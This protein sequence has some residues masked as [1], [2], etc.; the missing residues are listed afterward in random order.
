MSTILTMLGVKTILLTIFGLGVWT[1]MSVTRTR[2]AR[3]QQICWGFVLVVG[4]FGAAIP[5]GVTVPDFLVNNFNTSDTAPEFRQE[6]SS[7]MTPPRTAVRAVKTDIF[8]KASNT[9]PVTQQDVAYQNVEQPALLSHANSNEI[10]FST[11][12]KTEPETYIHGMVSVAVINILAAVWLGGITVLVVLTSVSYLRLRLELKSSV[13]PADEDLAEWKRICGAANVSSR[14]IGLLLTKQTGPALVWLSPLRATVVVP[15]EFWYTASA[16]VREAIL[17]HELAHW[18]NADLVKTLFM[19][20]VQWIHWFNPVAYLAARRA[21]EAME[22]V[23]DAEA[24]GTNS[25]SAKRFLE[26]MLMA[27]ETTPC[28]VMLQNPFCRSD[29]MRR[30]TRLRHSQLK[31]KETAMKKIIIMTL[32]IFALGVALTIN[33]Q[34][35]PK[36]DSDTTQPSTNTP[37]QVAVKSE[38]KPETN[39]GVTEQKNSFTAKVVDIYDKPVANAK[40]WVLTSKGNTGLLMPKSPCITDSNGKFTVPVDNTDSE[41]NDSTKQY[42]AVSSDGKEMRFGDF[43]ITEQN[44]DNEEQKLLLNNP[45]VRIITGTVVDS[46]GKPVAGAFVGGADEFFPTPMFTTSDENGNFQFPYFMPEVVSLLQVYAVKPGVGIAFIRTEEEAKIYEYQR[47]VENNSD[48][49]FNGPFKLTLD[50]TQTVKVRVVDDAGN[51]IP[52]CRITSGIQTGPDVMKQFGES[53]NTGQFSPAELVPTTDADGMASFNWVPKND[54]LRFSLEVRGPAYPVTLPD[55]TKR[56]FGDSNYVYWN[57]TDEVI[58]VTLPRRAAA[59]IKVVNEDGTPAPISFFVDWQTDTRPMSGECFNPNRKCEYM[60]IGNANDRCNIGTVGREEEKKVFPA[61]ANFDIGDGSEIKELTLIAKKGTRVFGNI[62]GQDGKPLSSLHYSISGKNITEGLLPN[63]TQF[64]ISYPKE[65]TDTNPTQY[66]IW[67]A[68]GTYEFEASDR[69][70]KAVQ[71]E[72]FT[73]KGTVVVK[74]DEDEMQLDLQLVP[75]E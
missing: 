47:K 57:K 43:N 26:S 41:Y 51:P 13:S 55:G 28:F 61:V 42:I 69:P 68:P 50:E 17:K 49:L 29:M 65:E 48:T 30:L 45:A 75:K 59:R 38:S 5:F 31:P 33:A 70:R 64:G 19:Q 1:I 67:L 34:E 20:C 62:L 16:E 73:A 6:I 54:L 2:D 3:I 39:N 35:K 11:N 27:Y 22:G 36:T 74:G 71:G 7:G 56:Y 63:V 23:C 4:L 10:N 60:L 37:V 46:S 52:G 9:E 66:E 53:F 24:F 15:E 32:A 12:K 14:R 72:L 21:T 58:N 8:E 44:G 18:K 25:G 40:V